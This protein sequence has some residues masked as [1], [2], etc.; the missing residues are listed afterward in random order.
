M[1]KKQGMLNLN[2]EVFFEGIIFIKSSNHPRLQPSNRPRLQRGCC[3]FA[4]VTQP[5][6]FHHLRLELVLGNFHWL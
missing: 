6:Q 4:F 5:K 3:E 2:D 1:N